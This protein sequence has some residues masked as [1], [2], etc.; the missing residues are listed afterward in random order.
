L[1]EKIEFDVVEELKTADMAL[2]EE[3]LA[4]QLAAADAL[5]VGLLN[6]YS[7]ESLPVVNELVEERYMEGSLYV[8]ALLVVD[9]IVA[10]V[11]VVAELFVEADA[12][13]RLALIVDSA[14]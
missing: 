5:P 14:V 11:F 10:V 12:V 3:Y 13:V 1:Q 6:A 9:Y 7:V 2:I 8:V 4:E